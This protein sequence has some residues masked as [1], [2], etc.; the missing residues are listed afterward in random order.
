MQ[1]VADQER[2][3]F[4]VIFTMI[5]CALKSLSIVNNF[6]IRVHMGINQK[7]VPSETFGVIL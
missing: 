7:L 4:Y 6:V 5:L 2:S 1:K 3:N